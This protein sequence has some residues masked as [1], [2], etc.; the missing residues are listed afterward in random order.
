MNAFWQ[1]IRFGVRTLLK[2][3]GF[4]LVAALSLGLGIGAITS[5]FSI[6]SSVLLHPHPFSD[7]QTLV[8]VQPVHLV[9]GWQGAVS[10][11]EFLDWQERNDIFDAITVY[12]GGSFNLTGPEG[13]EHVD[14]AYVTST[15]F[16]ILRVRPVLGRNFRPEEDKLNGPKVVMISE[17]LWKTRYHGRAD[18]IGQAITLDGEPFTVV[19][20][21][22]TDFRFLDTG[23]ADVWTP[24]QVRKWAGVRGSHWMESVAR[25]KAGVS[26][27]QAEASMNAVM[28]GMEEEFP[29]QYAQIGVDIRPFGQDSVD[30]LR[31]AFWILFGCVGFVLLIA[32]VNVANLLLAR[33]SAR[34]KEVTV[35]IALGAGRGRLIRQLLTESL[36][37]AVLGGAFGVLL[38]V[39]G[40]D[41]IISLL[42]KE[43]ARF[44]VNYFEFGLSPEVFAFTAIVTLGTAF[45]FGLVPALQASKP[46]LNQ[47]L[48]EGGGSGGMGRRRHR[49]LNALVVSEVA[50]AVVLL[51]CAG[52]MMQ[53]FR[54][55]RRV[56]PGF[57][58][59]DLLIVSMSLP[60]KTYSEPDQRRDFLRRLEMRIRELG[61]V[62]EVGSSNLVPFSDS[63]SNNTISIEGVPDPEPGNYFSANIRTTTP[64]YPKALGMTL[65]RGRYLS[66]EDTNPDTPV[67]LINES[68]AREFW[69]DTDPV[70]KR[71]KTGLQ[72]SDSP[73]I[74]VVG[75]LKDVKYFGLDSVNRSEFFLAHAQHPWNYFNLVIRTRGESAGVAPSVRKIVLDLD[76]NLPLINVDT[77]N[78][79]I[80]Q[81]VW[82]N[83]F[84]SI[85]FA[86]LAA[87][88]LAL[89]VIGV[90]GVINY[91]V[92]QRTHE[93]GVR[94]ALGAQIGDV[95]LLVVR[96]GLK[97]AGVGVLIGLPAAFGLTR[98][99]RSLLYGIDPGDPATYAAIAA[100]LVLVAIAASYL[101][102]RKATRV[103][104][105]IALRY[106]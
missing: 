16:P 74:T 72:D 5:V 71:F 4:T 47:S 51:I 9:K 2:H 96:Q 37:L 28:R 17:G 14:A 62:V 29:K 8:T 63:N 32:C 42:P 55:L 87:V 95:R 100:G 59:N 73:W 20:V 97:L 101:P 3:P 36:I 79:L 18:I 34:E 77:M 102:A 23:P 50:L 104:P 76:P 90:Y 94:M 66:D 61:G 81:S 84:N 40:N 22:P 6:I 45:F 78:S 69:P 13:P 89:A 103:D 15:F 25:L 30:E 7:P 82:M 26:L 68:M 49:V 1:D 19:G 35:R 52:L 92:A 57:D 39:W 38:S 99:M 83:R 53:S 31:V 65:L 60:E 11:P 27:Q 56:D 105:M 44:Y 80:A 67:A 106:E 75:L 64:D 48:K 93:I 46:D 54:N 21:V 88:A 70:G 43:E 12:S 86:V 98:L 91:S 10:Y 33:V 24:A 85:L 58:P 41:F